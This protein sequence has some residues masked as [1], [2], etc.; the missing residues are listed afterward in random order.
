[1][2]NNIVFIQNNTLI[3][4]VFLLINLTKTVMIIRDR[5]IF[6]TELAV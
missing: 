5:L 3:I 2:R 1:M 6:E 4:T